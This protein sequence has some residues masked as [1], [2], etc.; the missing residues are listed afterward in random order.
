E[1][2]STRLLLASGPGRTWI[3][4]SSQKR[5]R[6]ENCTPSIVCV[7]G[8]SYTRTHPGV[9]LAADF[10]L[11]KASSGFPS[12]CSGSSFGYSLFWTGSNLARSYFIESAARPGGWTNAGGVRV[13]GGV[14]VVFRKGI[15]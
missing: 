14:F 13:V 2:I 8:S 1:R 5:N 11:A 3:T 10:T 9:V 4:K 12:S 15:R 7:A 6:L